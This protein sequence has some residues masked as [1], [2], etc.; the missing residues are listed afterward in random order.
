[1]QIAVVEVN[2]GFMVLR[3]QQGSFSSCN[4]GMRIQCTVYSVHSFLLTTWIFQHN[5][6]FSDTLMCIIIVFQTSQYLLIVQR[7]CL[8]LT[9][10]RVC[11][12]IKAF[13]RGKVAKV[14]FRN[15]EKRKNPKKY[16]SQMTM[17]T[18]S[19]ER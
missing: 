17:S 1:M 10:I 19:S 16:Q 11:V 15:F 18:L 7:W 8:I 13:F 5:Y 12:C 2:Y 14:K 4:K 9:L 6:R 3:F